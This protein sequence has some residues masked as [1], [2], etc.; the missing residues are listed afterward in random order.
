MSSNQAYDDDIAGRFGKTNYER[1]SVFKKPLKWEEG[2]NDFGI[3]PAMHSMRNVDKGFR[4]YLTLHYGYQVPRT[5]D[6]TKTRTINFLCIEDKNL[7]T[8]MVKQECPQC[9]LY[10]ERDAQFEE[11]VDGY[12]REGKSDAEIDLLTES[13]QKWL[14]DFRPQ[15]KWWMNVYAKGEFFSAGISHKTMKLLEVELDKLFK[16]GMDPISIDKMVIWTLN[17]IGDPRKNIGAFTET[18]SPRMVNEE[19]HGRV[20]RSEKIVSLTNEQ[21]RQAL[22]TCQDLATIGEYHL[23]YDQILALTRC[24]ED[25]E[26]VLAIVSQPSRRQAPP[27][28]EVRQQPTAAPRAQTPQASEPAAVS[29][30]GHDRAEASVTIRV[31]TQAAPPAPAQ[32]VAAPAPAAL[33]METDEEFMAKFNIGKKTTG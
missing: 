24:T 2:E 10:N 31:A 29:S 17:R 27:A 1:R 23:T 3:L 12:K 19:F 4:R 25:P 28:Q 13:K 8:G 15:R 32:E 11:T 22:D 26:E 14:K 6:P 9:N 5:D 18:I 33:A 7:R 20:I 30:H 16:L 21:A